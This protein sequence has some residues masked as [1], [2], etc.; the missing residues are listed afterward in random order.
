MP[1]AQ[2]SPVPF[3]HVLEQTAHTEPATESHQPPSTAPEAESEL[4]LARLEQIALANNPSLAESRA[5]VDAA[6]GKWLQAG[7]PPNT[8]L[9]YSGQ[10]LGSGGTAEQQGLFIGQEF[11][12]GDKLGLSRAVVFHEIQKAEKLWA[13]QHQRVLTDV[14]LAYYEVL[15]AQ[16][17]NATASQLVEIAQQAVDTAEALLE[18]KEVSQVDVMRS[19]IELQMAQLKL[20]NSRTI[21]VAAWSRLAAVL[22][23]QELQPRPLHGDLE[24]TAAP[25]DADHV[26]QRL[27]R[28]SPEMGALLSDVERARRA[29]DRAVAEPVSNVDLQAIFQSDR[30]TGSTNANLQISIPIPRR[31]RNEGGIRQARAEVIAAERAVD[32]LELSF[33]Q[34][35]AGVYQRYASARNQVEDYSR[36]EGILANSGTALELIRK[37]YE[38]GELNYLDL[39]TAQRTFSQTT[40]AYIEALGEFWAAVVEIDGMLLKGSLDSGSASPW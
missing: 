11:I 38:A 9:G 31:N 29:V 19:R 17:R 16:R 22:G 40:L 18:A 34:R 12:R 32:Q 13:A 21:S 14:R 8:V 1:F 39:I 25:I 7:L 26:L 5:W 3:A 6:R 37:G 23:M 36:D 30:G 27:I 28:E 4:T 2:P 33:R 20:K 10:Q 24:N 35:L 15:V